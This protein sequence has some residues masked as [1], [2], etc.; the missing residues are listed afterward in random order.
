MKDTM[1]LLNL[2]VYVED[3]FCRF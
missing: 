1:E 2:L 3:I